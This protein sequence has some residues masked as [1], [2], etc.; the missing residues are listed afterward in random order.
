MTAPPGDSALDLLRQVMRLQPGNEL[1]QAGLERIVA[2]HVDEATM[3]A[4]TG[5]PARAA[6]LL[7]RAERV[8][9]GEPSVIAARALL[10]TGRLGERE[11]AEKMARAAA[12]AAAQAAAAAAPAPVPAPAAAPSPAPAPAAAAGAVAYIGAF[13]ARCGVGGEREAV[14][15]AEQVRAAFAAQGGSVTVHSGPWP[16][17]RAPLADAG[18]FH[19]WWS[20]PRSMGAEPATREV[21]ELGARAGADAVLL[22]VISKQSVWQVRMF[23]VD[24]RTARVSV[25]EG[26]LREARD[27]AGRLMSRFRE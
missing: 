2:F 5:E 19:R 17:A 22:A 12:A 4:A 15:L 23:L 8:L 14:K 18:D 16:D 11:R 10:A 1:A 7:T 3:A 27:P 25:A 21:A 6:D 24:T 13:C 26:T 20:G 9:P